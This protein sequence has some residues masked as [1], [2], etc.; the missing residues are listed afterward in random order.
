MS[1]QKIFKQRFILTRKNGEN[2]STNFKK[3]LMVGT[4][5]FMH[6]AEEGTSFAIYDIPTQG[7]HKSCI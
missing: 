3:S 1:K 5:A 7:N 6:A 4:Q 2:K